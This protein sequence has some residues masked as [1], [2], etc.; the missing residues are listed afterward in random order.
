MSTENGAADIPRAG[1]VG[2]GPATLPA[3]LGCMQ[4]AGRAAQIY[5]LGS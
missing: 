5:M 3:V 2:H 1:G 4:P